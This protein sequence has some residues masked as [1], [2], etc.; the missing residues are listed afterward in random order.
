MFDKKAYMREYHK[1]WYAK[2]RER[3]IEQV[4]AWAEANPEKRKEIARKYARSE[5]GA[6]SRR[7]NY[8]LEDATKRLERREQAKRSRLRY[9]EKA[10]ARWT[11]KDAVKA[12]KIGRPSVCSRCAKECKPHGHHPDYAKPLEVIWLCRACHGKEHRVYA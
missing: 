9:P 1:K 8:M 7:R 11:L 6:E 5:K 4:N 3:I 2:N 10:R 12:G